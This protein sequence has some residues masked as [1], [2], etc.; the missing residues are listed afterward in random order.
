MSTQSPFASEE[1]VLSGTAWALQAPNGNNLEC[2]FLVR[3]DRNHPKANFVYVG[4]WEAGGSISF[5]WVML[6][7]L[8]GIK[9]TTTSSIHA[10]HTT[11][12]TS[13]KAGDFTFVSPPDEPTKYGLDQEN[14]MSIVSARVLWSMLLEQGWK[15]Q[16]KP[17][18][19]LDAFSAG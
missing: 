18:I 9:W 3:D 10:K 2:E 11:Y 6:E 7:C 15:M 13:T 8:I 1:R 19:A 4:F 17:S 16:R 14:Y 12:R 5:S